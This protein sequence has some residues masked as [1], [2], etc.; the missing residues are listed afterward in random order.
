[1]DGQAVVYTGLFAETRALFECKRKLF[2]NT[3]AAYNGHGRLFADTKA[4][5][6]GNRPIFANL[7]ASLGLLSEERLNETASL[8]SRPSPSM[9]LERKD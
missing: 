3:R 6:F 1:M 8:I 4:T 7:R 5:L 9:S 2:A